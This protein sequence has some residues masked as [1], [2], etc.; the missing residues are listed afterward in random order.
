LAF[1]RT[2]GPLMKPEEEIAV[3]QFSVAKTPLNKQQI[4]KYRLVNKFIREHA[5]ACWSLK[6]E[7]SRERRG[8]YPMNF[9][10]MSPAASGWW[11][12]SILKYDQRVI[13]RFLM[14]QGVGAKIIS[15]RRRAPSKEH[16]G[17]PMTEYALSDLASRRA[18]RVKSGELQYEIF[19]SSMTK[20][21]HRRCTVE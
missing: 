13:I 5:E 4:A 12:F 1:V 9:V 16:T 18:L 8:A 14:N 2:F 10:I 11:E 17:C 20:S 3:W 6:H 19:V 15:R 7:S 21:Y